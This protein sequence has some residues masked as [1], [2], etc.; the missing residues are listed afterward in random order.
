MSEMIVSRVF[1]NNIVLVIDQDNAPVI[2]RGRGIGHHHRSGDPVNM[3][4]V[5]Q[6]FVLAG[7]SENEITGAARLV[8]SIEDRY[9]AIAR[10]ICDL[11][12]A[13]GI[14]RLPDNSCIG[15]ADHLQAALRRKTDGI[16]I[17]NPMRWELQAL[18]P[19]EMVFG[20]EAVR[21][22]KE[23]LGVD[24][25]EN[26]APNFALHALAANYAH[27]N[28][29]KAVVIADLMSEI[30]AMIDAQLP[31]QLDYSSL[32]LARFVTHLRYLFARLEQK[33][34]IALP[35]DASLRNEI[36]QNWPSAWGL[37]ERARILISGSLDTECNDSEVGYL[38]IH[39]Q[40]L[41]EDMHRG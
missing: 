9:L 19:R 7:S 39:I 23:A 10:K 2:L 31:N 29:P 26:E 25:G 17:E 30:I 22:V 37:A 18:Y 24:L 32:S 40:R 20:Q 36:R 27:G 5:E 14:P 34:S 35:N 16:V 6:K 21:L 15:I 8:S 11:A 33:S 41:I 12:A 13:T 1:N 38:A 28:M 3:D 4:L